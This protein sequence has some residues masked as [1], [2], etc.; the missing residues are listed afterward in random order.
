[1]RTFRRIASVAAALGTLAALT[2]PAVSAAAASTHCTAY[3]ALPARVAQRADHVVVHVVLRG[4]SACHGE[5]T[6]NGA[7]ADLHHPGNPTE[8]LRWRKFGSSQTVDLYINLDNVGRYVLKSGDVQVYDRQYRQVGF[9]WRTTTMTV[10]HAA[11]ITHVSAGGSTV[12]A[13]VQHYS[14]FGWQAYANRAVYVQRRVIGAT[15]WRS[16]GSAHADS[17]GRVSFHVSTTSN[18]EYRLA[19]HQAPSVWGTASKS[20]RG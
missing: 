18:H 1:M 16:L 15:T 11:R 9:T 13:R 4:S 19:I 2:V 10:K 8:Q 17:T 20:V 14:K 6:D 3:G 12:S 7:S 5:M